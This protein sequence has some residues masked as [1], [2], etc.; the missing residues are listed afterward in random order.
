MIPLRCI[1]TIVL[2]CKFGQIVC[3]DEQCCSDLRC[4][5]KCFEEPKDPLWR[6]AFNQIYKIIDGIRGLYSPCSRPRGTCFSLDSTV[7][8]ANGLNG[9]QMMEFETKLAAIIALTQPVSNK[10]NPFFLNKFY[11][12]FTW[13]ADSDW[14]CK[15]NCEAAQELLSSPAQHHRT[16]LIPL[17]SGLRFYGCYLCRYQFDGRFKSGACH[18]N[19]DKAKQLMIAFVNSQFDDVPP[20]DY[21]CNTMNRVIIGTDPATDLNTMHEWT[22]KPATGNFWASGLAYQIPFNSVNLKATRMLLNCM[23]K[24]CCPNAFPPSLGRRATQKKQTYYYMDNVNNKEPKSFSGN[25]DQFTTTVIDREGNNDCSVIKCQRGYICV[26]GKCIKGTG[27]DMVTARP[28]KNPFGRQLD[29]TDGGTVLQ[30]ENFGESE[31]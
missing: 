17:K 3:S 27:W 14:Q 15:E 31:E 28:L 8:A 24:K 19:T 22:V 5:E 29:E 21:P 13:A 7:H 2:L 30:K 11:E 12:Q 18:K 9:A 1:L 16:E 26:R 10:H 23:R 25:F 20:A 4:W 6:N